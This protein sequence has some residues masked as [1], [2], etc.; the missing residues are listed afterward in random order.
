MHRTY[1][2]TM[3]L[4]AVL[5]SGTAI[6]HAEG[7]DSITWDEQNIDEVV[8]VAKAKARKLQ[9]E[10]YAV[11]VVDLNR[12]YA[13]VTPL[14]KVLNTVSSVRIREDG[15]V[16]SSYTFSMNGFSG[17]QVKFFLDGIPMDN[18]GS[19]FNIANLSAN[20]A[21][22]VE[23]YKGVLPIHLGSDALGGAVN[24]ISRK[25]ANYLDATYSIGSF[26]THKVSVNGAYTNLESGFTVRANTFFN[27]SKNNY[28][29]FAPIVDL[30]T[31]EQLGDEWVKRFNDRYVSEGLKMETGFMGR[32]WADQLL[33]GLIASGNNKHVQTGA[34]M[35][36]VY[37][38]VKSRSF[39][40]I[41]SL[42][43]KKTNI[44]TPGFDLSL[45][46][47]YSIVNTHHVDTAH[48]TY[49]WKGD[50]I[51]NAD[52]SRGEGYLTNALIK[53]RQW[54]G[55]LNLNYV[56]NTHHSVTLNHIA[57]NMRRKQYDTEYPD[58]AMNDV[59][60]ILTK[61]IMGLSYQ[62]R[63]DKWNANIFGKS[64]WLHTSTHKLIDQFLATEHYEKVG[65]NSHSMGYGAAMT[66]F[67][68]PSLQVKASY[69]QAYRMPESIEIFGDGFI[70]KANPDLKPEKSNN[71]NL[72]L[73][74]DMQIN[75]G[76]HLMAEVN[77]LYRHTKDFILK[78]VS[79]TSDPTTSYDNIGKAIT[80]GIEASLQYRYK[81]TFSI[82]GNLTYQDI[83][84]RQKTENAINSY[85]DNGVTENITYGQRM[86]NIP[87]FFVN[88]DAAY[89]FHHVGHKGN[90]LTL[91]YNCDYIYKYY[92]SFPGLG[93][94]TSK[95]YIPTQVSHNASLSY[96]MAGG[97]Y[98][99]SLECENI[100]NEKLYDN[101]R[102]QKPGRS[103]EAKFRVFLSKI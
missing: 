97:K 20:I 7:K 38:R 61:N 52:N 53:E 34:T 90:T 40:L 24:I 39:S 65:N 1:F 12:K 76:H 64:Y 10:A 55:N 49:N 45:Y 8:V 25:K 36:A 48:V 67:I 50:H 26:G 17:N 94:P 41:P 11:S 23:V 69:E 98:S 62:I 82:G 14:D 5:M 77:Y 33:I 91:G 93:R 4:M 60:Q 15:G 70:Q 78:G 81:N 74:F 68:L 18:F 9:H 86:P 31:G 54:Q 28:K 51:K 79:L 96:L 66:Y 30:N 21:E 35:D 72:G 56:I 32:T 85:V 100:T 16:G 3:A 19:S 47:T 42:R 37:G 80:H 6:A 95:K 103:F 87:Y 59:P 102:L 88:G 57:S 83:K 27:T 43:Y 22:Q 71:L 29:V 84:D 44:F 13:A 99:V 58:Y 75:D 89:H 46:T 92:L 63:Y 2:K 73:L 101:Y